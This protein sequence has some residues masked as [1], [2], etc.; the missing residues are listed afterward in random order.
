MKQQPTLFR[1]PARPIDESRLGANQR[2]VLAAIDRFG[3]T[4]VRWAGRLVYLNRGYGD[5]GRVPKDWI[6]SAGIRVLASLKKR[7]L[8][9]ARRDGRWIRPRKVAAA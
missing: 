4:R 1:P 7:G 3:Y 9:V 8:V 2:A 5:P 6:D